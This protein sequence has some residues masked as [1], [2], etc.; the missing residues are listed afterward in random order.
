MKRNPTPV[1]QSAAEEAGVIHSLADFEQFVALRHQTENPE[2][3]IRP[4]TPDPE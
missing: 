2:R 4:M 3:M 1:S